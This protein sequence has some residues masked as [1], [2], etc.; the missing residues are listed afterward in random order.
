MTVIYNGTSGSIPM[1][2]LAHWLVNDPFQLGNYPIDFSIVTA[3]FVFIAVIAVLVTGY[4]NLGQTRWTE[5]LPRL[6]VEQ[7]GTTQ[8]NKKMRGAFDNQ[9]R[10]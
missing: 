9:I 4:K 1:V 7:D 5:V 2:F 3:V 10:V 8:T 6:G